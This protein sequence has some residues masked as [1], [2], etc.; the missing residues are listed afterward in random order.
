MPYWHLSIVYFFYFAIVGVLFPFW[1]LY[2]QYKGFDPLA[3]GQLMA[4]FAATKIIA[5]NLWHT[6]INRISKR[7]TQQIQIATL[8][9]WLAFLGIF[10]ANTFWAMALIIGLFSFFWSAAL[11]QIEAITFNHLQQQVYAYAMIRLWGSIGFIVTVAILGLIVEH[12]GIWIVPIAMLNLYIALWLFSLLIPEVVENTS[13][14]NQGSATTSWL[15]RIAL[16]SV[17]FLMQASHG[18]YY[19][20]YSIHLE[21]YGYSK[22]LIGQ[23]WALGVIVEL[24]LFLIMRQLLQYYGARRLLITSLSLAIL[25]WLL[26]GEF[27]QYLSILI[28]A[29][30]LHA[31][32]FG[33]FHAV[34]IHLIYHYFYGSYQ[35]LGQ[36]LYSSLSFGAGVSIG[37]LVGGY[38]WIWTSPTITFIVAAS[39][40]FIG[41]LV[42]WMW[43]DTKYRY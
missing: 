35:Y 16:L 1:G 37:S 9:S 41:A 26:I 2:L 14:H 15:E 27:P 11:P 30:S 6:L 34:A 43:V 20:F 21:Q 12:Y 40:A 33:V 17:C 24:G 39:V 42:A 8:L 32:T 13:L 38:L 29:Q 28:I 5:P 22:A 3:V 23:L 31:V 25:R 4:I 10:A 7:H 18:V 19:T 36:A